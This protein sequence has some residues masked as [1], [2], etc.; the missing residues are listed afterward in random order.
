M[1]AKGTTMIKGLAHA[2]FVV[3]DL[4]ASI[5]FYCNKLALTPA[6][7]FI[8]DQGKRFGV[9]IHVGGRCFIELFIGEPQAPG[10]APVFHRSY[11]MNIDAA[12]SA[13]LARKAASKRTHGMASTS[14]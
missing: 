7:D 2:C 5:D 11:G 1:P 9:Y 8:N 13:I 14:W 10:K 4:D 12:M 3:K 6:F